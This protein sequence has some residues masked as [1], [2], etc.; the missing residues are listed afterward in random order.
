M[1]LHSGF[2]CWR[3]GS[4]GAVFFWK[5]PQGTRHGSG[6]IKIVH[7]PGFSRNKGISLTKPPFGENRSCEVASQL[8]QMEAVMDVGWLLYGDL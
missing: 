7:Q 4:L 2:R 1:V 6:Q 8:D 3:H 5:H